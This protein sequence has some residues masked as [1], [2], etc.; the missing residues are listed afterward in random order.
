MNT[1]ALIINIGLVIFALVALGF[2]VK[3]FRVHKDQTKIEMKVGGIGKTIKASLIAIVTLFF[4]TLGIGC[5]A[6]MTAGFKVLKVTRDK[7]IPGTLN[8][9]CVASTALES[10]YFISTVEVDI[11]TLVACIAASTIGAY[12]GG[13]L[14]AKLNL[15]KM[16]KAMGVALLIVALVLILGLA[17]MLSFSGT[18][19]GLTGW[20][21]ALITVISLIMGGLMTIGIGIYAPLLAC[22]SLLGMNPLVAFPIML[23]CCAYLIPAAAIRF[24]QESIKSDVP[25]YDRKIALITN[26]IGLLGSGTAM[27][28]VVSLPMNV[29]KVLVT[30]IVIYVAVTMLYQGFKKTEDKVALMEDEEKKNM[31]S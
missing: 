23:G 31:T 24:C 15:N 25:K 6:T 9:A 14:V 28:L 1:I 29:L 30:I 7:Y 11:V 4:D 18:E 16:R 3:D 2:M 5:Y 8:V 19:I 21:L 10:V 27:V 20:R 26:T 22:V 12:L 13:G 17:G